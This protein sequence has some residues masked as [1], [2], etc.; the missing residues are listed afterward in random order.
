MADMNRSIEYSMNIDTNNATNNIDKLDK[1]LSK[2]ADS[3]DELKSSMESAGS[4]FNSKP[5]ENLGKS[6]EQTAQQAELLKQ[7]TDA[8]QKVS[9]GFQG[10][11]ALAVGSMA[12]FGNESEKVTQIM[13]KL[14]A[15][16]VI[17]NG[18][19]AIG[20]GVEAMVKLRKAT[21]AANVAQKALNASMLA[22]P[23]A[24][25]VAVIASM[26]AAVYMVKKR[27]D[28]AADAA[29]N[30]QA[31][32]SNADKQI[33][34]LG[35]ERDREIA[36]MQ[37]E[38]ATE[39][40][41]FKKRLE[42]QDRMLERIRNVTTRMEKTKRTWAG[43]D[44]G[45][46]NLNDQL[47]EARSKYNELY[48]ERKQMEE[49]FSN[50][51]IAALR[52]IT[53]EE[54]AE[55]EKQKAL[56]QAQYEQRIA[57]EAA[58]AEE[59]R[60]AR[61]NEKE[62]EFD[63]L[64]LWQKKALEQA[65]ENAELEFKVKELYKEKEK[66]LNEKYAKIEAEEEAQRLADE[67]AQKQSDLETAGAKN[68]FENRDDEMAYLEEQIRIETEKLNLIDAETAAWYNQA[69]AVETLKDKLKNLNKEEDPAIKRAQQIE[70][71]T[72]KM[73]GFGNALS[74]I[75]SAAMSG[76]DENSEAY[77]GLAITQTIIQT[78][79]GMATALSGAFTTKSGPW[80]IALAA[81]QAG[82]ILAGGIATVNQ[83]ANA[84]ENT[85]LDGAAS[86]VS[87]VVSGSMISENAVTGISQS[88]LNDITSPTPSTLDQGQKVYVLT[89]DIDKKQKHLNNVRTSVK[90]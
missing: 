88:T 7:K 81:L 30:Y 32:I 43:T 55:L 53:E 61:F 20:E 16:M 46:K 51:Q 8:I 74:D 29:G 1:S 12:L 80:D 27:W 33:T 45:L 70:D 28:E 60:T 89:T 77:K 41:I 9:A 14:S 68:A 48:D 38:G 65:H 6:F 2:A 54:Q 44:E 13:Q 49:D 34:N 57:E 62:K 24:A 26:A 85:N 76:L 15:V 75:F 50:S 37:A 78:L 4:S 86:S 17:T 90:F 66:A 21:D 23:I 56:R 10:A 63:D 31:V 3:A 18:L 82:G 84:N 11:F 67:L 73:Q 19:K 39:E 83:I 47:E 52:K 22:N 36:R 71:I 79:V 42:Y 35:K 87:S 40:D 25:V 64:K 72:G 5:V 58:L 69:N 59:L